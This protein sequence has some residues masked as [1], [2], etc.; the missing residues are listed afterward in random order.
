[1]AATNNCLK[2]VLKLKVTTTEEA[3]NISYM[4]EYKTSSAVNATGLHWRATTFIPTRIYSGI[5]TTYMDTMSGKRYNFASDFLGWIFGSKIKSYLIGMK[6]LSMNFIIIN[7]FWCYIVISWL[8]DLWR[9]YL[10][11]LPLYLIFDNIFYS[12]GTDGRKHVIAK[13]LL[14]FY[15]ITYWLDFQSWLYYSI[16]FI[17]LS[18]NSKSYSMLYTM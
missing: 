2:L 16:H 17:D 5:P 1:M 10:S 18:F 13:F 15:S 12:L 7:F 4:N 3:L 14:S 8:D 11:Q 6:Q 9:A